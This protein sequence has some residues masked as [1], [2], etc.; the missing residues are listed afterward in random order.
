MPPR[1]YGPPHLPDDL[2]ARHE[3][4]HQAEEEADKEECRKRYSQ[5]VY[6]VFKAYCKLVHGERRDDEKG[7]E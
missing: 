1:Y 3:Q 7:D 4:V 2:R 6:E 5:R